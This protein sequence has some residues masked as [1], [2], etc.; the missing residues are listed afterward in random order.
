MTQ[1][2]YAKFIKI[3]DKTLRD[4][5][6]GNTD[7]RLSVLNKLLAPG[8]FKVSAHRVQRIV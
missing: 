1:T 3:S 6:K 5:E 7:P 8:G 4:V 2:Q